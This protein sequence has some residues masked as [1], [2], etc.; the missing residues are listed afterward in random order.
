MTPLG[1]LLRAT[2]LA[3]NRKDNT[4]WLCISLHPSG[5]V[6][7]EY[8]RWASQPSRAA[9]YSRP[10]VCSPVHSAASTVPSSSDPSSRPRAVA[11]TRYHAKNP[12]PGGWRYEQVPLLN[13]RHTPNL[14]VRV[15]ISKIADEDRVIDILR[16]ASLV[17]NDPNFRCRRW[18]ADALDRLQHDAETMGT[19]FLDRHAVETVRRDY[20]RS[21]SADGRF[22]E[23]DS[24][25]NRRPKPAWDV[26]KN[27]ETTC[28][29]PKGIMLG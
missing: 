20:L 22:A 9:R 23:P 2:D 29:R 1:S 3:S 13:A 8:K 18:I 26:L 21:K 25:D 5:N 15:L 14:L 16:H 4:K 7:E 17:P 11:G 10:P 27:M 6:M 12:L 28:W 19:A 24:L